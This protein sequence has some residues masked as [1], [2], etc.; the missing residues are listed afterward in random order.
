MDSGILG[1]GKEGSCQLLGDIWV[2][3]SL[4]NWLCLL[5]TE[6]QNRERG[7]EEADKGQEE[8][9]RM[10]RRRQE[11]RGMKEEGGRIKKVPTKRK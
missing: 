2:E 1:V 6:W 9:R 7:R 3:G 8:E 11:G 4:P 5:T 10:W